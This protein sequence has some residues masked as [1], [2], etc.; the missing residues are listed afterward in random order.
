MRIGDHKFDDNPDL[1]LEYGRAFAWLNS[2]ESI[3]NFVIWS[4]L[5]H[6]VTIKIT[7]G[8]HDESGIVNQMMDDMM[9]GKKIKLLEKVLNKELIKD[10]WELNESRILLAHGVFE[11]LSVI[12][13][14]DIEVP[15]API[16]AHKKTVKPLSVNFFKS[17]TQKAEDIYK[18][19][20]VEYLN[21]LKLKGSKESKFAESLIENYLQRKNIKIG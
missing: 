19:L 21:R 10:L 11:R 1:L 8:I 5:T 20:W 7:G 9:L 12:D 2:V 17:I 18:R 3:L 14:N 15:L 4:Y 6:A 16:F 13:E